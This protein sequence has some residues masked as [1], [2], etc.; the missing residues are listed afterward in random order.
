MAAAPSLALVLGIVWVPRRRET[1][2]PA[3]APLPADRRRTLVILPTYNE[4]DTIEWVVA[5]VLDLPE[6]VDVL[7]VDDA[8]PDGT[9]DL[10]RAI[11]AEEPRVRLLQRPAKSGLASAYLDGF[12]RGLSDGYDLL[13]EM[14]SDLSH[15]PGELPRLLAAASSGQDLTVGSRY[16]A[17]G[18]VTDW[19]P[20]RIALSRAGNRYARFM[21]GLPVRDATSG[22]RVYRSD[23]LRELIA[24]P[25][26]SDGY[27]F[28]VELVW[29][30]WNAGYEIGEAPISFREREHGHSKLS[31]RI[32]VE[33]LWLVTVWGAKARFTGRPA[34]SRGERP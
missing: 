2:R 9:G 30:A 32:V 6:H 25:F 13:V 11:A 28:Q 16:V 34:P 24:R 1:K 33:A 10:V 14:D 29:R 19:S 3:P 12:R 17:G 27:G 26:R 20:A 18:S 8:S 15:A 31:R 23:L 7:V 21:L 5:R 4:R 22:F